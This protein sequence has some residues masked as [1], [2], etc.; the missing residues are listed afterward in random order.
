VIIK[1]KK[2]YKTAFSLIE[3]AIVVTIISILVAGAL[4]TM[5]SSANNAKIK[6]TN[7]R[8]QTIYKAFGN[9]LLVNKALPCPAVITSIKTSSANYGGGSGEINTTV[10]A[11]CIMT[12][13]YNSDGG[14]LAYGMVPVRV[15]GLSDDFAEDG[16]GSK[17]AYIVEKAS[18]AGDTSPFS[19][20]GSTIL[21][22]KEKPDSS[23]QTIVTNAV[24]AI[25][26]YGPN[27]SGAFP[28]NSA[29]SITRSSDADEMENDTNSG[30]YDEILVTYSGGSSIFDDIVFYKTRNALLQDFD[31]LSLLTCASGTVT[32]SAKSYTMPT[33]Y[34]NQSVFSSTTC[35]SLGYGGTPTYAQIKC[36]AFGV[37]ATYVSVPC[38]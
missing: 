22:I 18:T 16:F 8:I 13:V 21:T 20:N 33:G 19:T 32:I 6:I 35:A 10:G 38:V 36:G 5:T 4:A 17:F 2:K 26:S 14:I 31:A 15:L 9:Y 30:V 37:W 25:V 29:S 23:L 24:F 34:Y 12:G 1:K 11:N 3:L 28:A 7:D 27:K